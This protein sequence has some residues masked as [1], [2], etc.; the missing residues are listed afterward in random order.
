MNR[1]KAQRIYLAFLRKDFRYTFWPFI[2]FFTANM[3]IAGFLMSS[4]G[5]ISVFTMDQHLTAHDP[6]ENEPGYDFYDAQDTPSGEGTS[7]SDD[8]IIDPLSEVINKPI[9]P[10]GSN[11]MTLSIVLTILFY[12]WWVYLLMYSFVFGRDIPT[13]AVRTYFHYP[14]SVRNLM[15]VKLLHSLAF[16][17]APSL[18]ILF[19]VYMVLLVLGTYP[20]IFAGLSIVTISILIVITL[21]GSALSRFPLAWKNG[22]AA[23]LPCIG[24]VLVLSIITT[25]SFISG[26]YW[27]FCEGV[28]IQYSTPAIANLM[29]L[30]PIHTMGV[31]YDWVL[32]GSPVHIIDFLWVPLGIALM[33]ISWIA[34]SR[35]YPDIFIKETA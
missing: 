29:Y 23:Q 3:I 12:Y 19:V 10:T 31:L 27:A 22:L 30:S 9:F 14:I 1:P 25:E 11:A 28:G 8:E 32:A 7:G 33:I 34:S 24:F 13:K 17:V 26:I 5:L 16:T 6:L 35:I 20:T 18:P 15:D 4:L 21:I 2:M